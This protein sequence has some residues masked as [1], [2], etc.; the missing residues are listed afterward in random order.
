[1]ASAKFSR[2]SKA[3]R[4]PRHAQ[5]SPSREIHAETA[6]LGLAHAAEW[7]SRR[8]LSSGAR[9][10]TVALGGRAERRSGAE[11]TP[12]ERNVRTSFCDRAELFSPNRLLL[13]VDFA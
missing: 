10:K 4:S 7:F 9:H 11:K 5:A 3:R 12:S 6:I 2:F 13:S 1:V 8:A